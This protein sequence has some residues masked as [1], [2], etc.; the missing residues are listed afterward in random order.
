MKADNATNETEQIETDVVD[1]EIGDKVTVRYISRR[2][3]SELEKTGE[4]TNKDAMGVWIDA[5]EE[6]DDGTPKVL[7]MFNSGS[8]R[9]L[10]RERDSVLDHYATAFVPRIQVGDRVTFGDSTIEHDVIEIE[11]NW[12]SLEGGE[13]VSSRLLETVDEAEIAE[14]VHTDGVYQYKTDE[15]LEKH[16]F[17]AEWWDDGSH[18]T[19]HYR[20][21]YVA[22]VPAENLADQLETER[23]LVIDESETELELEDDEAEDEEDEPAR[24]IAT[25]GGQDLEAEDEAEDDD[26]DEDRLE[27][28]DWNEWLEAIRS[29]DVDIQEGDAIVVEYDSSYSD[30]TQ[31]VTGRVEWAALNVLGAPIEIKSSTDDRA[32][33]LDGWHIDSAESRREIGRAERVIVAA[34]EDDEDDLEPAREITTDGGQDDVCCPECGEQGFDGQGYTTVEGT[35][36]Y[37][38][39]CWSCATRFAVE[40]NSPMIPDGGAEPEALL[41]AASERDGPD[42]LLS[43][44]YEYVDRKGETY[45]GERLTG[46]VETELR[47]D[48]GR[49]LS[50]A[51][52]ERA[53]RVRAYV[54]PS[55]PVVFTIG[56]RAD[57]SAHNLKRRDGEIFAEP[58]TVEP[59]PLEALEGSR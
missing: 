11:G 45:T 28:T 9:S 6:F 50:E 22:D 53:F 43:V 58:A 39:K 52:I 46:D 20:D 44:E 13:T 41:E 17:R 21:G 2:T 4:V 48:S 42:V 25:D 31:R 54:A 10:G 23:I 56:I 1:L 57:G 36:M 32:I 59:A 55:L 34:P 12:I 8:L 35:R 30:K 49:D 24:E 40:D 7:R 3:G 15:D 27:F 33:V 26:E 51:G 19:L 47:I 38:R 18:C 16:T 29:G 5:G 14:V 37:L